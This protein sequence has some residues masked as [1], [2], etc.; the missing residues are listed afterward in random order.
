M[1]PHR[2][3][4]T[5]RPPFQ[6]NTERQF[7]EELGSQN[8]Q[9]KMTSKRL[10]RLIIG[11]ACALFFLSSCGLPSVLPTPTPTTGW[12]VSVTPVASLREVPIF[13]GEMTFNEL[14]NSGFT[15]RYTVSWTSDD[16]Q[17]TTDGKVTG[18]FQVVHE[19]PLAPYPHFKDILFFQVQGRYVCPHFGD[20]LYQ[21]LSDVIPLIAQV[22]DE[23]SAEFRLDASFQ[24]PPLVNNIDGGMPLR[25]LELTLTWL[26]IYRSEQDLYV[27]VFPGDANRYPNKPEIRFN[28]EPQLLT[29]R[30]GYYSVLPESSLQGGRVIEPQGVF[31]YYTWLR[32]NIERWQ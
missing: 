20:I 4:A 26:R 2:C 13:V 28:Q 12:P 22:S 29:G 11:S 25:N 16:L 9:A 10:V 1:K 8:E 5:E 15:Q 6:P 27:Q 23:H 3:C 17:I 14:N 18:S 24:V 7:S 31:E 19:G 32:Q 21:P 30:L